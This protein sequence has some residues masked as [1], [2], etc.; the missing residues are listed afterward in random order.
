MKANRKPRPGRS[1]FGGQVEEGLV[2]EGWGEFQFVLR[3]DIL[4]SIFQAPLKRRT[5]IK[6][7]HTPYIK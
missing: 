3:L 2:D 7:S 4:T 1:P 6:I 5:S